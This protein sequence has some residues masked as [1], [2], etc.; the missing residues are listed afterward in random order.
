ME[1]VPPNKAYLDES[2]RG[3][4]GQYGS[5]CDR[6]RMDGRLAVDGS[7]VLDTSAAVVRAR[8]LVVKLRA[9]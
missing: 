6:L 7:A 5:R 4:A 9:D 3:A 8:G 1:V 2:P